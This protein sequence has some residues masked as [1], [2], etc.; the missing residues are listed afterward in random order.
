MEGFAQLCQILVSTVTDAFIL[1]ASSMSNSESDFELFS[2][3]WMSF[4]RV[5]LL[6]AE[7]ANSLCQTDLGY[8]SV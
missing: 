3:L 4:M 7:E 5:L 8:S 6:Y 2:L 1:F